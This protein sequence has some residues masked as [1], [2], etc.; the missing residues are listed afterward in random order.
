MHPIDS[1]NRV[2]TDA[3]NCQKCYVTA[4]PYIA[5]E[6]T[7][8]VDLEIVNEYWVTPDVC[9]RQRQW[10]DDR[11]IKSIAK[12]ESWLTHGIVKNVVSLPI[13][14][15]SAKTE[16]L[17]NMIIVNEYWVTAGVWNRQ[18]QWIHDR[19]IQSIAK[20]ESWLTH[21]IVKNAMSQLIHKSPAKTQ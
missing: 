2:M 17:F 20:I 10:I 16:S 8:T 11:H 4:D 15:S 19:C 12:I 7:V 3:W 21:G 9:N 6:K 13:H 1:K 18:R 5:G 14:K